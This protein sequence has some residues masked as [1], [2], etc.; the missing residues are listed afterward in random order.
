[1]GVAEVRP[2]AAP[3]VASSPSGVAI[4]DRLKGLTDQDET[5]LRLVGTHLGALA[6]KDLAVRCRD[7]LAHVA[8]RWAARKR[9]LTAESSARWA[10]AITKASNDQ[11]ALAR[12]GQLAHFQA[13]QAGIATIAHRL[14]LPVGH[15][16]TKVGPGGYRSRQEWF[17]KSRRLRV[18]ADRL[19][20]VR[21]DWQA[22][23]V[24][25]VRGGK[26]LA[27]MR[28]HLQAAGLEEHEWRARWQAARWFLQADGESG[29]RHGNETIRITPTGEVSIRLPAPLARL[30]NAPHGR[31]VLSARIC[32]AHRGT[33]WADRVHADRAV[34]YR[35]HLDSERCRWYLTAS[36]QTSPTPV[37][38]LRAAL[39]H[40]VIG[41]DTNADHLAAWRLDTHGNPI[42]RSRRFGYDLTGSAERRDAQVRHALTRLLSWSKSC[43]VR[44]IAIEDLDFQAEKTREKHGRRKRFRQL[45]SGLPTARL[46]AR[47]ISMAG[48]AG[49]AIVA[50]DPAYTSKW[51]AQHWQA[52]LTG[53]SRQT[54]RHD[55]ASI[56][57]GRRALGHPIRRRTAPPPAHRSDEQGHRTALARWEA[58]GREET[59]PPD[60]GSCTRCGPP[61]RGEQAGDQCAQ[62]RSGRT[63]EQLLLSPLER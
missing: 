53:K 16:G 11:W 19:A 29:K 28:H 23:L 2:I 30:A 21:A 1:M 10:G 43:G 24:R 61:D 42:G 13:L 46:R 8:D 3:Y 17:A 62:H 38:P 18:L 49:I 39:T 57:I 32:F 44:A 5:V 27:G 40:G 50:V 35:I 31:Y 47:L 15:K 48:A 58:C 26:R 59:R 55:A 52:P 34:A 33:E 6:S 9:E 14:S 45:I 51:G 25:I 41:V 56:A 12:R 22:G 20:A 7:G 37:V 36:W 4:R 63:A 60:T 54:T